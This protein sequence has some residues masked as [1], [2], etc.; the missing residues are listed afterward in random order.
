MTCVANCGRQYMHVWMKWCL[1][2]MPYINNNIIIIIFMFILL[3][4]YYYYYE[5]DNYYC[6]FLLFHIIQ[7]R[8]GQI[9]YNIV[10]SYPDQRCGD[11][12]IDTWNSHCL[13][14]GCSYVT[15]G[16]MK[17]LHFVHI[18]ECIVMW[19]T[20]AG[21]FLLLDISC[22]MKLCCTCS[23]Y[24]CWH[25]P[26]FSHILYVMSYWWTHWTLQPWCWFVSALHWY[27]WN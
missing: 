22:L 20:W 7:S 6:N 1:K 15:L 8:L 18:F 12:W 9:Y 13:C 2:C 19:I 25:R 4:F 16:C 10:V 23:T 27:N 21:I 26:L 11:L 14:I 17:Y 24:S 3:L 5:S